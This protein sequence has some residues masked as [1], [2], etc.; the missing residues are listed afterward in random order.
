MCSS[1]TDDTD[2]ATAP[3]PSQLTAR[4]VGITIAVA[5]VL[6][7]PALIRRKDLNSDEAT[8]AVVARM[9]RHGATLYSGTV[10]RKPPGAFV[11][12][13]VLEPVFGTWSITAARWVLLATIIVSAW[14][15]AMEAVRR[16]PRVSALSVASITIA[17]F[18]ILPAEDSRAVSFE[19]LAT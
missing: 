4:N 6:F 19:A 5:I 1:P 12:F 3:P 9:M 7:L 13:R 17:T 15:L 2:T 18:S 16:W 14:L 11:L 8:M 10:D